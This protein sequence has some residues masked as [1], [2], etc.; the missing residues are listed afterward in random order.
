MKL[1][2]QSPA[3]VVVPICIVCQ[4][5]GATCGTCGHGIRHLVRE[6]GLHREELPI[7][8]VE[9]VSVEINSL[10]VIYECEWCTCRLGRGSRGSY[11]LASTDDVARFGRAVISLTPLCLSRILCTIANERSVDV[12]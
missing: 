6:S 9:S 12:W 11:F 5:L 2:Y 3:T 7:A 8:N 10:V 1:L 4:R